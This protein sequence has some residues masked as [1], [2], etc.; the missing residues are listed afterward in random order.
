MGNVYFTIPYI[1]DLKTEQGWQ[2]DPNAEHTYSVVRCHFLLRTERQTSGPV[3]KGEII[4]A[5]NS[6]AG[7][8]Q[9]VTLATEY[10]VTTV[11]L[12][13]SVE[14]SLRE[15]ESVQEFVS[16]L[17]AGIDLGQIGKLSS[18]VKAQAKESLKAS[19][20]NTFKVQTS[21]TRREKKTVTREITIDPA[22]YPPN[23]NLVTVKAYKEYACDL[24]LIFI[25]YL[26][27]SYKRPPLG[28]RLKRSKLPPVVG[29]KHPN[30]VRLDVPLAS[31][32]YW[33]QIPDT[34][35]LA[36]ESTYVIEV[37]DPLETRIEGLQ[38]FNKTYPATIP[39]KPS[40][41]DISEDVFPKKKWA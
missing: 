9:K 17:S 25:D 19:F 28:V 1:T 10:E 6:L 34:L 37:A 2:H 26:V 8:T 29:N 3:K 12:M 15:S 32:I 24:Y 4:G 40:L 41:Y 11:N 21:E 23:V 36:D 22:K 16:S 20:K 18:E 38:D 7:V 31:L 5:V 33:K 13:E 27:V 39:P 14:E 35:L 30:I